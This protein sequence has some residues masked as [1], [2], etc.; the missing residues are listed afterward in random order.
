M[1]DG[2]RINIDGKERKRRRNI[3]RVNDN[4]GIEEMLV[5]VIEILDKK[6]LI[7]E[8]ERKIID[9][10]KVMKILEKEKKERVRKERKVIIWWNKKKW[11]KIVKEKNEEDIDMKE[12]DR[13][14][15]DK[16]IE[17]DEVMENL[18]GGKIKRKNWGEN[19]EMKG[20]IVGDGR[21][22]DEKRIGK[23]K[24]NKKI[25]GMIELKKMVGVDNEIKVRKD[26]I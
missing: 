15:R 26:K 5:K 14:L 18:E 6:E 11:K 24:K 9:N 17:N 20:K 12:V 22:I 10:R 23:G 8:G 4:E 2:L 13:K 21:L 7:G 1:R 19:I 3:G 25:N 16:M